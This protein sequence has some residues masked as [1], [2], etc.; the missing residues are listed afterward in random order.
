MTVNWEL[1][2]Y[3]VTEGDIFDICATVQES[4]ARQ[5]TVD[6]TYPLSEGTHV[7]FLTNENMFTPLLYFADF[8]ISDVQLIFEAAQGPQTQCTNAS[9]T[10]DSVLED[11]EIHSVSLNSTDSDVNLGPQSV[12]RLFIANFDGMQL[13]H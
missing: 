12:T 13:L 6:I 1:P 10:R 7:Y 4:T 8:N 9:I 5:F 11:P 3:P 2:Q